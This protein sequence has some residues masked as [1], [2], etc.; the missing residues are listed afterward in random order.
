MAVGALE[1]QFWAAFTDLLELGDA[2]GQFDVPR[3]PELRARIAERFA[4]RTQAEW[5]ALFEGTDA[6]VSP[7]LT[8]RQAA[9]HPHLAARGTYRTEDGVTQPAPAPR[10][11]A[12]PGALRRPPAV[13]GA[14]TAEVA[15]DWDVPGLDQD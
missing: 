1:P 5:T 14:H 9:E 4:A 10:F 2:P 8:L 3:W 11:S 6:C 13:P 7:V 12:T 15:R